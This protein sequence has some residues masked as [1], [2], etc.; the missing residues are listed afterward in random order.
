MLNVSMKKTIDSLFTL[1]KNVNLKSAHP[2]TPTN[3][4]LLS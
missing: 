1:A 4:T 3:N 2:T